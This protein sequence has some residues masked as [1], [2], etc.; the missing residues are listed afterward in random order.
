[1]VPLLHL[2]IPALGMA[3]AEVWQM[4]MPYK[5]AWMPSGEDRCIL[6]EKLYTDGFMLFL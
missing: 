5:R 2:G 1:M 3:P 6:H 4:K